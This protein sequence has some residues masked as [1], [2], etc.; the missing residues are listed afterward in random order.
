[1]LKPSKPTISPSLVPKPT[2]KT[3]TPWLAAICAASIGS[4]P[5][6]FWPSVSSTITADEYEPGGTGLPAAGSA[7]G[8]FTGRL[9]CK[10]RAGLWA[11][12]PVSYGSMS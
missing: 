3:L 10:P 8:A 2:V 6:V 12:A 9:G 5:M 1:M 7:A 11:R 4:G